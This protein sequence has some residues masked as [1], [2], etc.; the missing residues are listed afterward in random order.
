MEN[1]TSTTESSALLSDQPNTDTDSNQTEQPSQ[2]EGN[3]TVTEEEDLGETLLKTPE[4]KPP[5]KFVKEDGEV[6]YEQLTKSYIELEKLHRNKLPV[7]DPSEYQ[8][9]FQ[10]ADAWDLTALEDFKAEAAKKGFSNDQ[11]SFMLKTFEDTALDAIGNANQT[12]EDFKND[13]IQTPAKAKAALIEEWGDEYQANYQNAQI[14]VTRFVPTA[15]TNLL[16]NPEFIKVM[17]NIGRQ[18]GEDTPPSNDQVGRSSV[19]S[20]EQIN[21]IMAS[22]KYKNGDPEANQIVTKWYETNYK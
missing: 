22:D 2:T 18:V 8:Y 12:I 5:K 19:M 3:E 17:A 20:R 7:A 10:Q 14:A 21:E 1:E 16:N 6:D 4:I 11:L 9:T 13:F 15:S